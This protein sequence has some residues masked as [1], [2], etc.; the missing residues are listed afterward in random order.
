M[1]P[2]VERPGRDAEAELFAYLERIDTHLEEVCEAGLAMD[3]DSLLA[4]LNLDTRLVRSTIERVLVELRD[5]ESVADLNELVSAT[6]REILITA[7]QPLVIETR[8][9]EEIPRV[10]HDERILGAAI[11]RAMQLCAEHA[12]AGAHLVVSTSSTEDQPTIRVSARVLHPSA[13][14]PIDLRCRTLSHLMLDLGGRVDL[15]A[16]EAEVGLTMRFSTASSIR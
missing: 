11:R 15:C 3:P 10:R 13:S 5:P 7:A 1:S 9:D 16:D 8:L 12:G 6:S 14:T 2:P 4:E